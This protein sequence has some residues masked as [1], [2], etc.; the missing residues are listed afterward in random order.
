MADLLGVSRWGY[1]AW[2]PRQGAQ[3]GPA[4]LRRAVLAEQHDEWA[5]QRRYLGLDLMARCRAVLNPTTTQEVNQTT[6]A[7]AL[8][9]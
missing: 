4:A 3:P 7:G 6:I 8:S 2:A 9:A 5:E 1:Y